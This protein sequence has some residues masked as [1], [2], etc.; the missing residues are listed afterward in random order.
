MPLMVSHTDYRLRPLFVECRWSAAAAAAAGCVNGM[1][2]TP[3]DHVLID[4][5]SLIFYNHLKIKKNHHLRCLQTIKI[6]RNS[7]HHRVYRKWRLDL[8]SACNRL[9]GAAKNV[10][11]FA[12][13]CIILVY[14]LLFIVQ[15]HDWAIKMYMRNRLRTMYNA[16]VQALSHHLVSAAMV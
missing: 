16:V 1:R 9:S 8:V 6:K 5:M 3:A 11:A 12:Y 15:T 10:N 7:V 2:E 4:W 13:K 14:R